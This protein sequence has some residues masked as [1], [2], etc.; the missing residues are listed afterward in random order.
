MNNIIITVFGKKG[1]GKSYF[2]KNRIFPF[3]N[4]VIIFDTQGEY[5]APKDIKSF[6]ASKLEYV[7]NLDELLE[8][9]Y[10]KD[11][12]VD[13]DEF[14]IVVRM[15]KPD[16]IIEA[17]EE[18]FELGLMTVIV[19]EIHLIESRR[20]DILND[21]YFLGRHAQVNIIGT[22]QRFSSV[23]RNLTSQSDI[24]ASFKQTEQTD[25][26]FAKH[27]SDKANNLPNLKRGE[28]EILQG[29]E[30]FGN[31]F[32]GGAFKVEKDAKEKHERLSET[33]RTPSNTIGKFS[34]NIDGDNT[35]TI[36]EN[37]GEE[38]PGG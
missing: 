20:K 23:T 18:I 37:P 19:E 26:K 13:K 16:E 5:T 4:R 22:A 29:G 38:I 17:L 36:E 12:W 21:L 33:T 10:D 11:Y 27:Y 34:E 32:A 14:Y 9:L 24:I 2:V 1:T 3:F 25:I 35:E 31:L 8:L 7:D 15:R 28:F 6:L 30:D